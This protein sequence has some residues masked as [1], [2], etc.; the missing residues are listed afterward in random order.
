MKKRKTMSK[1][2][3]DMFCKIMEPFSFQNET[4]KKVV[5]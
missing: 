5:V 2:E 1:E 3:I 4:D